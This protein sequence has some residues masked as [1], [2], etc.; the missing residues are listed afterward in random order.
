MVVAK[1][2]NKSSTKASSKY[3]S[4]FVTSNIEGLKNTTGL[5]LQG[6]LLDI[7]WKKFVKIAALQILA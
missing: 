2:G 4:P 5:V 3:V 1:D 7:N 6:L